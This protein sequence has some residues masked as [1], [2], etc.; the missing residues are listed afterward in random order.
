MM[1]QRGCVRVRCAVAALAG[2]RNR[3]PPGA[4]SSRDASPDGD[5]HWLADNLALFFVLSSK[6]AIGL[7]H[8]SV[9]RLKGT[10]ANNNPGG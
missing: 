4:V 10:R 1:P 6:L 5:P 7:P 2:A 8:Y 9:C 3:S